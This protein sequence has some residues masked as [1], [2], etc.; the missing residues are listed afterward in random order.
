MIY[1]IPLTAVLIEM[2]FSPRLELS[3]GHCYCFYGEI[4]NSKRKY[5][6]IW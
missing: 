2:I 1:L 6:K 5:F 3:G 4:K